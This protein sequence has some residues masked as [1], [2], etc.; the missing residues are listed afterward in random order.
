MVMIFM[1]K[2]ERVELY[3]RFLKM[4]DNL[5]TPKYRINRIQRCSTLL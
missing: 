2:E 5:Q 4:T 1:R 3:G